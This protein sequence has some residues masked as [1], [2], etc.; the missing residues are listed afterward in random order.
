MKKIIVSSLLA[1]AL[2]GCK[3]PSPTATTI[4]DLAVG[5]AITIGLPA[6]AQAEPQLMP[7]IKDTYVVLNGLVN[8]ASTNSTSQ[9]VALIGKSART[10]Q[11]QNIINT[12]VQQ[13][14]TVEQKA[15]NG[16]TNSAVVVFR[17]EA[18]IAVLAWP[19]NLQ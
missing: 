5:A 16:S 7:A 13:L 4:E 19:A 12:I 17:Q 1:V 10:A 18:Q 3:S 9:L 6:L 11:A 15:V 2:C 14:S 8:G